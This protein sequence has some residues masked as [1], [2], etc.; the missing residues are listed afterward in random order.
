MDTEEPRV[1]ISAGAI[2]VWQRQILL[3]FQDRTKTWSFPKGHLEK[4]EEH[5]SA[6][7]R[8]VEEESGLKALEVAGRLGR[9][10]RSTR[11]QAGI[12]KQIDLFIFLSVS[13]EVTPHAKDVTMC[14]WFSIDD[15]LKTLSYLEERQFLEERRARIESM[16]V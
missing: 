15:A 16:F 7:Q 9:Y 1:E 13:G 11:R 8:E 14:R 2:V 4:G 10:T 3:V 6:A 12:E 5:L